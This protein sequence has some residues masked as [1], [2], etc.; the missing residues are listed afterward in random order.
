MRHKINFIKIKYIS[1][2]SYKQIQIMIETTNEGTQ[3]KFNRRCTKVNS[4]KICWKNYLGKQ[5]GI[6]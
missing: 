6:T 2:N 5:G 4:T 3:N 1:I